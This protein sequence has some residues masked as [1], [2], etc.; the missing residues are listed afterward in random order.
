MITV[1][2]LMTTAQFSMLNVQCSS[3]EGSTRVMPVCLAMG[4]AAGIA[5]AMAAGGNS[6]V[7]PGQQT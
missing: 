4:E 3:K 6:L 1:P 7:D 5:A 2:G